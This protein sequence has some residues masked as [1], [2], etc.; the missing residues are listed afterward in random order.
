MKRGGICVGQY[1]I[2]RSLVAGIL[3]EEK[4]K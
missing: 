4:R 2:A 3:S 1:L